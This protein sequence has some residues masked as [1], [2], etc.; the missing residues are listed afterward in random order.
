MRQSVLME[1]SKAFEAQ[2]GLL[3]E[4][5]EWLPSGARS[6]LVRV[7]G[8]GHGAQPGAGLPVL[9]VTAGDT[10]HR[11]ESL[12]DPRGDAAGGSWRGAYVVNTDL[13]EDAA[14][15]LS[16]EF[17]GGPTIALPS[18]IAGANAATIAAAAPA[19][20][21]ASLDD[22]GELIDH[23][24]LADRRAR[25][26]E[27]SRDAQAKIAGEAMRAVEVLE[28]RA[29]QLEQQLAVV[30]SERDAL[31]GNVAVPQE[32]ETLRSRLD[33][34]QQRARALEAELVSLRRVPDLPRADSEVA[35]ASS[36][37]RIDR[38]RD[39]LTSAVTTIAELRRSLR[40]AQLQRLTADVERTANS[41]RLAVVEAEQGKLVAELAA[42]R[43]EIRNA[44]EQAAA[45]QALAAGAEAAHDATRLRFAEKVSELA[46]A[47][48]R[49]AGLE[50]E[51]TTARES[52]ALETLAATE[53][54]V[55]EREAEL[56][57]RA[58]ALDVARAEHALLAEELGNRESEML[59]ELRA[60]TTEQD[61]LR[62]ALETQLREERA[63][64][65]ADRAGLRDR[66]ATAEAAV[67][68]ALTARDV[69]QAAAAAADSQR[70]AAAVV[71]ASLADRTVDPA[72]FDRLREQLETVR[73]DHASDR[74]ALAAERA[75]MSEL[76]AELASERA[77]VAKLQ[78]ELDAATAP[79]VPRPLPPEMP[80]ALVAAPSGPGAIVGDR[81]RVVADLDRAAASLRE[82]GSAGPT[83]VS[84]KTHLP[85]TIALGN[86]GRDYPTLRG[87]LVKLAHDDPDA[88]RELIVGLLPAQWRLLDKPLDYDL[89]IG[90]GRTY[91]VEVSSNSAKVTEIPAPR[92]R[93]RVDFHVEAD[94][95]L[96]SETLAEVAEFRRFHGPRSRWGRKA[97]RAL[98]LFGESKLTLA[99]AVAAGAR[100]DPILV[101]RCLEYAVPTAWTRGHDFVIEERITDGDGEAVVY[102]TARDGRG[103]TVSD[104]RPE[105]EPS[106][107]V[108][109]SRKGFNAMLR[110]QTPPVGERPVV[111]GDHDAVDTL[112]GWADRIRS[113]AI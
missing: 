38:L 36:Q 57:A 60:Q 43:E 101:L 58:D 74:Q 55:A 34:E 12:P 93:R 98:G 64:A 59:A 103:I 105:A 29:G 77:R 53:A 84:A 90:E 79:K 89:T 52:A 10:V 76:T 11:F 67:D 97:A 109:I 13:F 42:A 31:T 39:A 18:P 4:A 15:S 8:N 25:R 85:R 100:L 66:L 106:A 41:V 50:Q 24:V 61:E 110:G 62:A 44:H 80:A 23:A 21:P 112:R 9:L 65:D 3:I 78:A 20:T 86:G 72:E 6:G 26:A 96:L 37:A 94:A 113:S 82:Q 7:R 1:E 17:A 5:V 104:E 47:R 71:R 81:A 111:R 16:L 56:A 48:E 30:T 54:A 88:A 91:R 40:E 35:L 14:D 51:L 49:I 63:A 92:P 46:L 33:E 2:D 73:A 22:G 69:A 83:I 108:V 32:I 102:V 95:L 75:R 87:A 19:A 45:A 68:A 99:E 70:R 27:A 28:L 107:T